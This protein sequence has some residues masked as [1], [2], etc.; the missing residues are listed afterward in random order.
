MIGITELEQYRLFLIKNRMRFLTPLLVSLLLSL[1]VNY[2]MGQSVYHL[3]KM[4]CVSGT[5]AAFVL[6]WVTVKF[7]DRYTKKELTDLKYEKL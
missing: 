6:F 4:G 2:K 7:T 1:P 5:V 3:G